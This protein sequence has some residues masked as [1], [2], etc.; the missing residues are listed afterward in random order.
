[1]LAMVLERFRAGAAAPLVARQLPDPVPGPGELLLRVQA[2]AVC[3][4]DLHLVDGELEPPAALPRVPGHQAVG[5]IEHV[6]GDHPGLAVGDQVGVPWLGGTCGTCR[7]CRSRRENL[8]PAATFTDYTADGGY[9]ELLKAR[10]DYV[11]PLAA[12]GAGDP[13]AVAPLLCAGMIGYRAYRRTW[14]ALDAAD[15]ALALYGYGSAARLLLAVAR[16]DG[17]TVFVHTRPRDVRKQ[18]EARA[19]GAA[20]A[21]GS[22]LAPPERPAAAIIFAPAGA[23]VTTAL[24]AV[25]R[26]GVVVC[27]GIHMSDIPGFRYATLWH[28]RELCSV[29]NLT[30][31]DGAA[32]LARAVACSLQA[33][34][35][36]FALRD[37]NRALRAVRGGRLS[38]AAVLVPA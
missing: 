14:P 9:A 28:E 3:R 30:R 38:G 19:A 8:C 29:A 36:T 34:Y 33:D 37:A 2:C 35:E 18:Q 10:A 26:G 25:E 17:R 22:D 13:A 7:F 6:N 5:V 11:F 24:A 32:F 23:L 31:N 15:G 1:M 20:W 16:A 27:A 21:G 4:T 12:V